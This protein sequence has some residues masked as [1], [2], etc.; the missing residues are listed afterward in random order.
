MPEGQK[1][2]EYMYK[3]RDRVTEV[4]LSWYA[5][6]KDVMSLK[7]MQRQQVYGWH[8][9][10]AIAAVYEEKHGED[11][12]PPM[13][14][15]H[16]DVEAKVEVKVGGPGIRRYLLT[17]AQNN[18]KVHRGFM[19]NLAAFAEHMDAEVL[20]SRCTY[21]GEEHERRLGKKSS[22]AGAGNRVE[23]AWDTNIPEHWICDK[24]V[25][26][27]EGLVFYGDADI[28][29][30]AATPLSGRDGYG[31]SASGI[32]PHTRVA[33]KSIAMPEGTPVKMNYTTGALTRMN[34]VQRTAGQKAEFHHVF[35]ALLVEVDADGRWFCRQIIADKNG[36]FHDLDVMV[37]GGDICGPGAVTAAVF[38][39]LHL[40]QHDVTALGASIL[41]ARE[42][43]AENV[44]L[45]D[46]LD[47]FAGSP[48]E[49]D[50]HALR[51]ERALTERWSIDAEIARVHNALLGLGSVL[52]YRNLT[53]VN[54]NHDDHLAKWLDQFD[55]KRD[56][57]NAEIWFNLQAARYK[58]IRRGTGRH[59]PF[60]QGALSALNTGIRF[61]KEDESLTLAG[62]ECGM[63][64]HRGA[65]GA[66]GSLAGFARMGV[67]SIV[68]HS[69]SAG[70]QDG[71]YQVGTLSKLR[72]GYNK[73]PSSW[74]HTNALIYPS[75]KRTLITIKDGRWR[76]E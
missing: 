43:K 59:R 34:Y 56:V 61:L 9:L 18:T 38:G 37:Y 50:N 46:V 25:Q 16:D 4:D 22:K 28:S 12:D 2:V 53:V 19:Q 35:G 72:K 8:M 11:T 33:L 68:G 15:G 47:M 23:A 40:P 75:G 24:R 3:L 36:N 30:T 32:F 67:R 55:Y 14:D 65:N 73:G 60:L 76:A 44:V 42:L 52:G 13:S 51:Y 70:I 7:E 48:H 39:D 69:H 20:V 1:H 71:A 10:R 58:F 27:A 64:G 31:G 5:D 21:W 54:S 66:R 17:V 63:H 26:L 74:S 45:H 49:L 57:R 6:R 41:M 29:P 62:V